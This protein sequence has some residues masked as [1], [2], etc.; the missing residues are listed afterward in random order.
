MILF[1][2]QM[3]KKV[4]CEIPFVLKLNRMLNMFTSSL[5]MIF[6]GAFNLGWMSILHTVSGQTGFVGLLPDQGERRVRR[7][8][9]RRETSAANEATNP[10]LQLELKSVKSQSD[11]TLARLTQIENRFDNRLNQIENRFAHL[12]GRRYDND[13]V[14]YYD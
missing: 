7:P 12:E 8:K 3:S 13:D 4:I 11:N 9:K 2:H 6:C 5:N 10:N 14:Y 1:L